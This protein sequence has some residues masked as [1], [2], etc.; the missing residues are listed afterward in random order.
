MVACP[1]SRISYVESYNVSL[2]PLT[3]NICESVERVIGKNLTVNV[4][5][6]KDTM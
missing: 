4:K 6:S 1:F 5:V 3:I 2:E